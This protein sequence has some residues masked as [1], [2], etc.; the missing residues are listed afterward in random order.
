[1]PKAWDLQPAAKRTLRALLGPNAKQWGPK[2]GVPQKKHNAK[3]LALP[4]KKRNNLTLRDK[5]T[6]LAYVDEHPHE[7]Q[8]SVVQHFAGLRKGALIFSQSSI[9]QYQK[10]CAKLKAQSLALPNALSMKRVWVVT[11]PAVDSALFLWQKSMEAKGKNT[12]GPML[13][14]K[15]QRFEE[16]LQ[17]PEKERLVRKGW[18]SSW[19]QA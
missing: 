10:D 7:S 5:M 4:E 16:M 9:S 3:T 13:A 18:I 1:M 2:K 14:E 15:R 11:A 8:E 6:V 12:S 17:I 19:K